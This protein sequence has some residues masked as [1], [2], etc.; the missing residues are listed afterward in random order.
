MRFV[1]QKFAFK[2]HSNIWKTHK[3][4]RVI[5]ERGSELTRGGC[6][7]AKAYFV[8][9]SSSAIAVC[10]AIYC[11]HRVA[12]QVNSSKDSALISAVRQ[13][14]QPGVAIFTLSKS[15]I[16]KVTCIVKDN[17]VRGNVAFSFFE[18]PHLVEAMSTLEMPTITRKQLADCWIPKLA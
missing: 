15:Q 12:E 2:N 17:G 5:A 8:E 4:A 10:K 16:E 3:K 1:F 9:A 6:C 11:N 7:F 13:Q 18:S 14:K